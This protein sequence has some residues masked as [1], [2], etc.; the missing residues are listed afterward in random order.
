[1][2]GFDPVYSETHLPR[3]RKTLEFLTSVAPPP[4]KVLDMGIN[5]PFSEM[6][7]EKGYVVENT[8]D[9]IDLDVDYLEV[10]KFESDITTA[11]EFFNTWWHHSMF[12]EL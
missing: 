5:N 10:T 3:F 9:G 1:M 12:S 8:P 7:R 6:M 2:S 4:L 11:F